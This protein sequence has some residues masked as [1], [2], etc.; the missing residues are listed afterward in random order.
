MRGAA[1]P[2]YS[3][4]LGHAQA[5][6]GLLGGVPRNEWWWISPEV[7][8]HCVLIGRLRAAAWYA[9]GIFGPFLGRVTLLHFSSRLTT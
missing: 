1:M 8:W 9:A 2:I 6:E 7:G 3:A 4:T 5:S